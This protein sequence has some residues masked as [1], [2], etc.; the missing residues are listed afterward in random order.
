MGK[1]KTR[2][3]L[4]ALILALGAFAATFTVI[5]AVVVPVQWSRQQPVVVK[6]IILKALPDNAMRIFEDPGATKEITSGDVLTFEVLQ[7]QPPLDRIFGGGGR[8]LY[9]RNEPDVPLSLVEGNFKILEGGYE[10]KAVCCGPIKPGEVREV[11]IAVNV[12]PE[13]FRKGFTLVIGAIGEEGE[14]LAP[15]AASPPRLTS[16]PVSAR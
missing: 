7:A 13:S 11:F 10:L 2:R 5:F 8:E 15:L 12:V 14:P 3:N 16:W 1:L 9:I 6:G 4:L